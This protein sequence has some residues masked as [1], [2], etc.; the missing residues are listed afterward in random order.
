[1]LLEEWFK[2]MP[3]VLLAPGFKPVTRGGGVASIGSLQIVW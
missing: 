3:D 1:V 2:R